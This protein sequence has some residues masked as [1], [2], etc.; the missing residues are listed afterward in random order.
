MMP[1][2]RRMPA[3]VI[4]LS[5]IERHHQIVPVAQALEEIEMLPLKAA[6]GSPAGRD[7]KAALPLCQAAEGTCSLPPQMGRMVV[8]QH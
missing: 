3:A 4:R 7:R 5:A 2:R 6:V 8:A 1:T